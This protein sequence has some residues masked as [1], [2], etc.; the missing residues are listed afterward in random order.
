MDG[1][2]TFWTDY[3]SGMA[4]LS[5]GSERHRKAAALA[6]A[7]WH[8]VT[9]ADFG[10]GGEGDGLWRV[11]GMRDRGGMVDFVL[12]RDGQDADP[13]AVGALLDPDGVARA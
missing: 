3:G 1:G 5:T 10:L 7:F 13:I 12:S 6:Y 2:I 8:Q 9:P 11:V 4:V